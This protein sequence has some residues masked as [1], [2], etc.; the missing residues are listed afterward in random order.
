[1]KEQHRIAEIHI[2]PVE[3]TFGR[4]VGRNSKSDN[5]GLNQREWLVQVMTDSGLRGVTNARPAMNRGSLAQLCDS[6]SQLLGRDVFEFHRTSGERVLGVHPRWETYLADHGFVSF[7]LFDLMGR[8]LGVPA[9]KL[10]SDQVRDRVGAYDSSLY[11]QDLIHPG[12]GAGAVAREAAEAVQKGWRAVK[13]KIGRPGKWFEPHA[14]VARDIEVVHRVREAVGPEVRI[15]VDANNGYDPHPDLLH[16]F[17]KEIADAEVFWMEEMITENVAGYRQL[18]EWRDRYTPGTMLVDGEGHRG[19]NTIY[20]QLMEEELLDAIQPDMLDMGFWPFH[21]LA[22][23]IAE[24]GLKAKIAPHNFNAAFVGLRGDV[25]FGAV[26]EQFVIAE[27]STLDF[28]LYHAPGYVFEGGSYA[29][30]D[31]PGLAVEI[32]Q[33]LY[34]RRHLATE[35]V[36]TV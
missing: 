10:L 16:E 18:R 25:Q 21:K 34:E 33:E 19:R 1:M 6:L 5:Y 23:D 11:F 28:D 14:G 36:L 27:D 20:W 24:S 13:L 3:T 9:H 32:D 2:A 7:V 4:V 17:V 15:L 26:T 31:A 22:T 8:A 12:E 35:T 30:P 29:V